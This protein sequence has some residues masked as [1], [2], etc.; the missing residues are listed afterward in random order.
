MNSLHPLCIV[1][2]WGTSLIL[3]ETEQSQQK[4][5]SRDKACSVTELVQI[6]M[7]PDQQTDWARRR[8]GGLGP[9]SVL[10]LSGAQTGKS[11]WSVA[12]SR[13]VD[14]FLVMQQVVRTTG[15]IQIW[16][17][18]S[19]V[20]ALWLQMT[21]KDF[22]RRFAELQ[23]IS[24]AKETSFFLLS[25]NTF[26]SRYLLSGFKCCSGKKEEEEKHRILHNLELAVGCFS[27]LPFHLSLSL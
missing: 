9:L 12:M 13:D 14:G 1:S 20:N 5:C 7:K 2:V 25:T 26:H 19:D 11:I 18:E 16:L 15:Q 3:G 17:H 22:Q 8:P 27:F 24:R 23:I 6:C 4:P 21:A 10:L